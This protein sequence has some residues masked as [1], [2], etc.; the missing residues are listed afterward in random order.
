MGKDKYELAKELLKRN[1]YSF[2]HFNAEERQEWENYNVPDEL[3]IKWVKERI[4]DLFEEI[5][6]IMVKNNQM[7]L[8]LREEN[9]SNICRKFSIALDMISRYQINDYFDK[10]VSIYE[11]LNYDEYLLFSQIWTDPWDRGVYLFRYLIRDKESERFSSE[12]DECLNYSNKFSFDTKFRFIGIIPIIYND[13][14]LFDRIVNVCLDLIENSLFYCRSLARDFYNYSI[15][16]EDNNL[17]QKIEDSIR[18]NK[19]KY[20]MSYDFYDNNKVYNIRI[21]KEDELNIVRFLYY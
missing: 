6:D 8:S 14:L 12:Y 20:F 10:I 5:L 4:E 18:K 9:S 17:Q 11:K 19:E 15:F 1:Y 3:V 13:K 2:S 7:D 21:K 16:I